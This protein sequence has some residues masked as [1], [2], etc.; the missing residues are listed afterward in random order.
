VLT[1]LQL[2]RCT[3]SG[4]IQVSHRYYTDALRVDGDADH[5]HYKASV[6]GGDGTHRTSADFHGPV[7]V[8]TPVVV[9]C[10]CRSFAYNYAFAL[11]ARGSALVT[12]LDYP[13][14]KNPKLT[15]GICGHLVFLTRAAIAA[16]KKA[17]EHPNG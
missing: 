5:R 2:L 9:S 13:I 16:T 4:T 17:Q 8:N 11:S 10:S 7:D 14:R 6:S 12:G 1:L 15:P 3:A